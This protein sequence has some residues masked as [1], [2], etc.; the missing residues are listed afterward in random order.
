MLGAENEA[1]R[2]GGIAAPFIVLVGVSTGQGALPFIV[3]GVASLLAGGAIFTLPETLGTA[4]PDTMQVGR[5]GAGRDGTERP[6]HHSNS[7]QQ[8]QQA[9]LPCPACMG[10]CTRPASPLPPLPPPPRHTHIYTHKRKQLPLPPPPSP[11]PTMT[12]SRTWTT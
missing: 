3:F 9:A 11:P 10:P 12:L 1:A 2:V 6:G 8:Q 7:R 4:L 5:D